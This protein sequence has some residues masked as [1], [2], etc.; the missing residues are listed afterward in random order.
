MA[1]A[2]EM[3]ARGYRVALATLE[4]YREKIEGT[5]IQFCPLRPGVPSEEGEEGQEMIRRIMDLWDGPRYV[6]SELLSPF[7]RESYEDTIAALNADGGADLL[8]SHAVPLA[9]PIVAAKTG[10][11]WVSAVLS[12]IS[13]ASTYDIPTPA[14]APWLR[15]VVSIHPLFAKAFLKVAKVGTKS[16][17]KPVYD[18]RKELGLDIGQNPIFD[19]QHSRLLVLAL[20]STVLGHKHP[21]HPTNSLITGFPFYD[22]DDVEPTAPEVMQFLESGEPPMIFTLGS[23]AVHV[24]EQFFRASVEAARHLK[25]RALL[26]VG[27]DSALLN[28]TLPDGIAAFAYAPHNVVMPQASVI[29]HQGGIGTTGQ[30]LRAGRPMLIVPHGQDQPDNARRCVELGVGRVLPAHRYTVERVVAALRD[31]ETESSYSSRAQ[32][33]AARVRA[34][35]GTKTAC[36]ALEEVLGLTN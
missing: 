9:G 24:G 22:G 1:L 34:E 20:Y 32:E 33:V 2:L 12:P 10:I 21:D 13:M 16:W 8:V 15:D 19:G 29:I 4:Y 3:Q 6:M 27:R 25:R 17:A 11:K 5:G 7:V 35:C 14:Q 28:E 31:L 36:D 18:F 30:A 23:A 26:L